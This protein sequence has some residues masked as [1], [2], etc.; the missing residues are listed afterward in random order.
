[1]SVGYQDSVKP[2]K[3]DPGLQDL[4]LSAFPT[5]YEEPVLFVHHNLG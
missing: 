3:T 4:A 5:V 1:V 2:F